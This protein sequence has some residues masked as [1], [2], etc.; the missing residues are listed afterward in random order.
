MRAYELNPMLDFFVI[1]RYF[2]LS[3]LTLNHFTPNLQQYK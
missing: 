1:D 3:D 2:K